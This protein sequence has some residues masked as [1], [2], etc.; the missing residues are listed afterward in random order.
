MGDHINYAAPGAKVGIQGNNIVITGGL[1]F[2]DDGIQFGQ[3]PAP[4]ESAPA[5]EAPDE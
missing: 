3:E 2:T 4:A 1:I 5:I